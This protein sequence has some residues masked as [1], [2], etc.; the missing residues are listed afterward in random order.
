L[1]KRETRGKIM[2]YVAAATWRLFL[3]LPGM[4]DH[5]TKSNGGQRRYLLQ[6]GPS[7]FLTEATAVISAKWSHSSP[8]PAE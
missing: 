7:P 2:R 3:C 1:L 5:A 4:N 6:K 8:Y